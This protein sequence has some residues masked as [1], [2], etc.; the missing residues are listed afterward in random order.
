[1]SSCSAQML[2]DLRPSSLII[3]IATSRNFPGGFL[4]LVLNPFVSAYISKGHIIAQSM[5]RNVHMGNKPN[6]FELSQ[7][8]LEKELC[9]VEKRHGRSIKLKNTVI[10]VLLLVVLIVLASS[11][12]F[13]IRLLDNGQALLTLRTENVQLGDLIVF[14]RDQR[15][16][17]GRIVGLA[18][19]FIGLDAEG[20]V[21][22]GIAQNENPIRVPDEAVYVT[23][24]EGTEGIIVSQTM[25]TGKAIL[26]I[27]PLQQLGN[28]E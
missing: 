16:L 8:Q 4:F 14:T 7:Q 17:S 2:N 25:I 11:I 28:I 13:P 27:W 21:N 20:S 12:W 10:T 26:R 3:L 15:I 22:V 9:R 23:G 1:M 6:N 5:E 24:L 18:G 19:D